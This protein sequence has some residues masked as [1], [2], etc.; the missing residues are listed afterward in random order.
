MPHRPQRIERNCLNCGTYVV[1]KY[2]HICGQENIE[3]KESAWHLLVHLFE[4]ITHFDGKF[5]TSMKELILKPGFLSVEYMKGRRAR[6]LNPLRMYLFTSFIFFLVFFSIYK[7]EENTLKVGING[8][9]IDNIDSAKLNQLSKHYNNGKLL[10]SKE[11]KRRVKDTGGI[12]ISTG[13]YQTIAEYDS[14]VKAGEKFNWIQKRMIYK[15]IEL[16]KKYKNNQGS[17]ASDLFSK[18]Q[19]LIPQM[20]FVLLPLFALFLKLL[21]IRRKTFYYTDHAIFTIHFYIFV[22]IDMLVIFGILKLM[23]LTGFGWL[24][25]LN[26]FFV[27]LLFFYLYKAMRSFYKQSTL[28]IILK[29][30]LLLFSFFFAAFFLFIIF[31]FISVFQ[32]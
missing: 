25:Y 4:D 20:L 27:L 5:F 23:D 29:Y 16:N 1:G 7:I 8:K 11:L 3:P 21:Y 17:L 30:L 10:T 15:S 26:I 28:K 18:F 24:Q 9:N 19:H 12:H 6:Y 22:F 2:C 13:K 31:F 32:I 14:A